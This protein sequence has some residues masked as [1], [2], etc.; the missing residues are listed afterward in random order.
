MSDPAAGVPIPTAVYVFSAIFTVL[1]GLAGGLVGFYKSKAEFQ[2]NLK[3]YKTLLDCDKCALRVV[4]D[5]LKVE[6]D[7]MVTDIKEHTKKL[8]QLC[9]DV[10]LVDQKQETILEKIA[11]LKSEVTKRNGT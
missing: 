6:S 2:S 10:K 7:D 4:V 11:E 9:I 8:N 5:G 3:E 1:A